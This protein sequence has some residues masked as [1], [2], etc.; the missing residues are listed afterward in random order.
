MCCSQAR[1]GTQW[2]F[3]RQRQADGAMPQMVRLSGQ[4]EYSQTCVHDGLPVDNGTACVVSDSGP[5]AVK[6]AAVWTLKDGSSPPAQRKAWFASFA[7]ILERGMLATPMKDDL[8][9]SDPEHYIVGFGF[10][11]T[12]VKTG[13]TF[14][15]SVL[16][17]EARRLPA[18]KRARGGGLRPWYSTRKDNPGINI[19]RSRPRHA[20]AVAVHR[21][22]FRS[23]VAFCCACEACH[24]SWARSAIIPLPAPSAPRH[25]C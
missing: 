3:A 20:L 2:V 7:A 5:F 24:M 6:S 10:A 8:A 1:L 12:V 22:L 13:H 25:A 14:Y 21:V 17:Y 9:W 11:D 19:A 15:S 18:Q 23:G 4:P 16:Y